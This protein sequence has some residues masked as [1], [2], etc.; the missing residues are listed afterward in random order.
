L[1]GAIRWLQSYIENEVEAATNQHDVSG[2]AGAGPSKGRFAAGR[3]AGLS[4]RQTKTALRVAKIPEAEFEEAIE[5][6]QR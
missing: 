6:R 1:I 2:G 3:A 4:E 5:T